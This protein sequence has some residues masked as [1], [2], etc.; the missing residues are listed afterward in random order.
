MLGCGG[1]GDDEGGG[2]RYMSIMSLSV[3]DATASIHRWRK[4]LLSPS[5]T[6][7]AKERESL[8]VDQVSMGH[9]QGSMCLK[10]RCSSSRSSDMACFCPI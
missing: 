2:E 5:F 6:Y 7:I 4:M 10:I 8:F 3:E 9:R 1:V